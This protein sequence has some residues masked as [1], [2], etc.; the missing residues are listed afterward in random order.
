MYIKLRCC[1]LHY[2][3]LVHCIIV[4]LYTVIVC[5]DKQSAAK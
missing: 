5:L 4:R 3:L 2:Y 1:T